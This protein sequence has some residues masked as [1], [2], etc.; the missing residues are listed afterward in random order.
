MVWYGAVRRKIGYDSIRWSRVSWT[1][2]VDTKV[3]PK[4]AM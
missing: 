4:H 2:V 1:E 3:E